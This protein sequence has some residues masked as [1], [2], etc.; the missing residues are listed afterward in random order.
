[1][2]ASL[3]SSKSHLINT[4]FHW[5]ESLQ[6]TVFARTIAEMTGAEASIAFEGALLQDFMLPVL[7]NNYLDAYKAF[8]EAPEAWS[9]LCEFE[10]DTFGWDHA[11]VAAFIADRWQFPDKL[12][13]GIFHHHHLEA[14]LTH[15]VLGKTFVLPVALAGLLPSQIRQDSIGLEVIRQL[16]ESVGSIDFIEMARAVD[17]EVQTA[18]GGE[19]RGFSLTEQLLPYYT[20]ST[21]AH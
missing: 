12:V 2:R 10:R 20:D 17:E 9:S 19:T 1:M 18:A 16:N 13:C 3:L 14:I 11:Q 4:G 8:Q 5:T 7:T 6:R 15:P 21:L